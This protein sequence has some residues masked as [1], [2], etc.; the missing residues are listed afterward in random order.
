[1]A[2][3]SLIPIVSG[4]KLRRFST[5]TEIGVALNKKAP[6][7]AR[8]LVI[9]YR[10][11]D[12]FSETSAGFTSGVMRRMVTRRFSRSSSSVSILR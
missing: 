12:Q 4:Y 11:C 5:A 7:C 9:C 2:K 8:R 6:D 10:A 3:R 1:M